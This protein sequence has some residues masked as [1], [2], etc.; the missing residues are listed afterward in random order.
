MTT[1]LRPHDGPRF[2]S[3]AET[4]Q[5]VTAAAVLLVVMRAAAGF[6]ELHNSV[7]RQ[8]LQDFLE[9]IYL[10]RAARTELLS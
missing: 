10:N 2:G 7:E 1:D 8:V 4:A 5:E 6:Q 3:S 9:E